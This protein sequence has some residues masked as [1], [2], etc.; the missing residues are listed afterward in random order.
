VKKA[1]VFRAS[2]SENLHLCAFQWEAESAASE[3]EVRQ[4]FVESLYM[5]APF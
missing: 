3:F 1:S 4:A 2:E 5:A